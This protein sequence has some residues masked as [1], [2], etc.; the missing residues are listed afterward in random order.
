MDIT[1][2]GDA[3]NAAA[4]LST[5]AGQGE[6]LVSEA[7]CHAAGL[8]IDDLEKRMLTLKGRSDAMAVYVITNESAPAGS[9]RFRADHED[10][11][12]PM[13]PT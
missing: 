13:K 8:R 12:R 9:P 11:N 6:I 10:G 7:A 4:R 1:V 5:M 3:A 2:L